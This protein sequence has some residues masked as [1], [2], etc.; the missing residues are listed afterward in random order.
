MGH[1]FGA[2]AEAMRRILIDNARRKS[3]PKHGGDRRRIDFASVSP[4]TVDT[5]DLLLAV[6]DAI[7]SLEAEFPDKAQLVKLRRYAGCTMEQAAAALGISLATAKRHWAFARAYLYSEL[8][9]E[10]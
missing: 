7:R 1:F 4:S 2:A 5:P 8:T 3:R 10:S 9:E 6:D